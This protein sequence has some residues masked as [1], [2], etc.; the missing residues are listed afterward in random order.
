[1]KTAP[2]PNPRGED[3]KRFFCFLLLVPVLA[4]PVGAFLKLQFEKWIAR[5]EPPEEEPAEEAV[6]EEQN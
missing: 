4:V 3:V 2:Y 1:M 5:K 6:P